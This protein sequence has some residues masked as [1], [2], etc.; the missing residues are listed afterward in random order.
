MGAVLWYVLDR[1]ARMHAAPALAASPGPATAAP[2][3]PL[4]SPVDLTQHDA[5]TIDFSSGQ[6]VV[7]Q[8]P[9]DKAALEAGL[10]DI[11]AATKEV[12]F[13]PPKKMASPA[14]PPKH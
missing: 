4:T 11:A 8:S 3:A 10:R 12:T 14:P 5:Q 7:K 13:E 9:E 2:G 6:P 1:R